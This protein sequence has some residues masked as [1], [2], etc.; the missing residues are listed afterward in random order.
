MGRT[1]FERNDTC[2]L[3]IR[4]WLKRCRKR[5]VRANKDALRKLTQIT[6]FCLHS[7]QAMRGLTCCCTDW[8]CKQATTTTTTATATAATTTT[9]TTP[10]RKFINSDSFA[11]RSHGRL[12]TCQ[13]WAGVAMTVPIHPSDLN[14]TIRNGLAVQWRITVSHACPQLT[15]PWTTYTHPYATVRLTFLN[16]SV[17]W[18]LVYRDYRGLSVVTSVKENY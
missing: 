1:A 3:S 13:H 16:Q 7:G 10:S 15:S 12:A 17:A 8:L 4:T 9:T 14:V 2:V 5:A 6:W 18:G 11:L